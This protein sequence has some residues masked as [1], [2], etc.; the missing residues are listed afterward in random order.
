M[1]RKL[2]KFEYHR[3]RSFEEAIA[4]LIKHRGKIRPLA[5]GTDLFI[6]MKERGAVWE[7]V[8]DLKGIP[9]YDFI[10]ET[11]GFIEIGAMTTIR[12]VEASPLLRERIPL[13]ASAATVLGSIQVRNKAT[14]GGNLCNAAPSADTAPA[15]LCLGASVEVSGESGEKV[16][17][18]ENFFFGPG[19]TMLDE[20]M[21]MK[22]IIVPLMP[23]MSAGVYFKESPRKAMDIAVAGISCFI[24]LDSAKEKCLDCRIAL[25]AVAP[26]PMRAK[27]AENKLI[28]SQIT[29]EEVNLAAELAANESK[30]IDDVRGSAGFRRE[31]VN[32][33]VKK[34]LRTLVAQIRSLT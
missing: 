34:G 23:P 24:T 28:N 7:H 15:L 8:L 16:V 14:L 4:A 13:L 22:K 31:M 2:P 3:P 11:N 32:V 10:R 5:G 20:T 29:E 17:P 9:D 6:A 12:S 1:Y 25:G 19:K 21:L 30:P 26:I 33:Y 18:L 27:N